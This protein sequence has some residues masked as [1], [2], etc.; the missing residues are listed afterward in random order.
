VDAVY[1]HPRVD[2]GTDLQTLEVLVIMEKEHLVV[3]VEVLLD[4]AL[5]N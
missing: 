2:H 5:R 3:W 1:L 4:Q